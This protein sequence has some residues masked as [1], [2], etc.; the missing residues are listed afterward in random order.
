MFLIGMIF[1]GTLQVVELV[2][3]NE[4]L[5]YSAA[6]SARCQAVGFNNFM[7][8]KTGRV[9]CIPNAG[10][11]TTPTYQ[12]TD[13]NLGQLVQA[14]RPGDLFVNVVGNMPPESGQY[15][16]ERARIPNYM[17]AENWARANYLLKYAGWETIH[18]SPIT[19]ASDGEILHVTAGQSYTNFWIPFHKAFYAGDSIPL[20]GQADIECHYPLYLDYNASMQ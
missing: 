4:I 12:N 16:L 6:C 10:T 19:S 3:A 20:L 18:M 5:N 14:H 15:S 2:S 17:A 13:A 1:A 9:A 8:R 11:M 7:C